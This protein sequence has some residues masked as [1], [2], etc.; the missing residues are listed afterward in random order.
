MLAATY[1]NS[2]K[3]DALSTGV[4][5][6]STVHLVRGAKPAP[7]ADAASS[8]A[9]SSPAASAAAASPATQPLGG[10]GGMFGAGGAGGGADMMSMM[11]GMMGGAGAPGGADVNRMQQQLLSNPEMMANIMNSP[12]MQVRV[13]TFIALIHIVTLRKLPLPQ[14]CACDACR[15]L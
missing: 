7:A 10:L 2:A 14:R 13:R 4:E 1:A 3:F 12:M 8:A 5:A 11:Q 9:A 15:C 6:D